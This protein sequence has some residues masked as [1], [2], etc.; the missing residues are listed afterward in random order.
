MD[1]LKEELR[2]RIAKALPTAN[3]SFEPIELTEKIMSQGASTPI[4]VT[5]AAKDLSEAGRFA[6]KIRTEMTKI[7]FLRDVQIAQPLAY[8]VLNVTMNRERAGQLGVTSTQVARSMV[9]ATSSSR[10]TDK[11]LWLDESKGLAYQVQVQ[12]PEY[13]MSSASD[14]GNI[15]LEERRN[16]PAAIGR[17]HVFGRNR[18]RRI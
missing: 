14:I 11:N 16:A 4:E 12:I 6:N 2:E 13:Q 8:P 9:A 10:F 5:V 15:P 1:N 3:I 17:S 7:D 18:T